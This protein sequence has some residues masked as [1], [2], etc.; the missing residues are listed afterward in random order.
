MPAKRTIAALAATAVLVTAALLAVA[1]RPSSDG[2]CDEAIVSFSVG[3]ADI[4]FTCEVADTLQ[5]QRQGLM[6]RDNLPEDA[7]MLFVYSEPETLTFWMK[8]T[9]IPLDMVFIAENGS[10]INVEEALPEP[11]I[12]DSQLTRY[13][14]DGPAKW[15]VELNLGTCSEH[16]IGPG[17]GVG[18][19]FF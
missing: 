9:L 16:G 14:S 19:S 13:Y 2:S 6:G 11:G 17:T 15:V 8:D 4:S 12:S 7:G 1:L 3:G 10:V 18:I 5:E